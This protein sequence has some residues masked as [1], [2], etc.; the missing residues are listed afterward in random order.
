MKKYFL[1]IQVTF[2]YI[3]MNAQNISPELISSSGDY[4]E[5]TNSLIS[6]SIGEIATE[7]FHNTFNFLSQGFQQPVSISITGVDLDLLVFLEGPYEGTQM[8][9]DLN[10]AGLIPL[11]QPY[12]SAPWNYSG[13][14]SVSSIPNANVVD[15]ILIELRDATDAVSATPSTTVDAKAC[16]LLK[17]GSV[18]S[19]DGNSKPA[20]NNLTVQHS[21]FAVIWHRNHLGIMSSVGLPHTGNVYSWDFSTAVTQVYNGSAGYKEIV[22]GVF[23]MPGGDA[24]ADGNIN[25]NDK[26]LWAGDAGKKG[27]TPSDFDL[28]SQINNQDKNDIYVPNTAYSSQVPH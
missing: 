8:E 28:N 2:F 22:T 4:F 14:E 18:V 15:W 27:Y 25:L 7:T 12:N 26:N 19:A 10:V 24:D 23:G 21:L 3:L 16:L 1:L 13:T 9:T 20:F 17:D 11:N 6:F 5:N